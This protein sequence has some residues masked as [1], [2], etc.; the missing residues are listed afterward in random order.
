M[1]A[2]RP[3]RV[4][5]VQLNPT[6]ERLSRQSPSDNAARVRKLL[7]EHKVERLDLLVLPEMALTGEQ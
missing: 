6:P 2:R 1:P 5:C 7:E 3:I 4:G